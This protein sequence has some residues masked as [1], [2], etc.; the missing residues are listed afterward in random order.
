[1]Q[2]NK[3][4]SDSRYLLQIEKHYC[5]SMSSEQHPHDIDR[6]A[7][8]VVE[9][10]QQQMQE[11]EGDVASHINEHDFKEVELHIQAKRVENIL[12]AS[13]RKIE[14][15]LL[16]PWI[17]EADAQIGG[18]DVIRESWNHIHERIECVSEL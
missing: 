14:F 7:L 3:S 5:R 8:A 12:D 16:L 17:F 4:L 6:M 1:M 13:L 18:N 15:A 9:Q 11:Y 10:I 2:I